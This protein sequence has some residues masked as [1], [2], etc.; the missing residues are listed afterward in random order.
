MLGCAGVAEWLLHQDEREDLQQAVGNLL[1]EGRDVDGHLAQCGRQR[2]RQTWR[3]MIQ[4]LFFF[5]VF[6]SQSRWSR[7]YNVEPEPLLSISAPAPRL[8]SR[9]Y[10]FNKYFTIISASLEDARIKNYFLPK[11][12]N[13]SDDTGITLEVQFVCC[14]TKKFSIYK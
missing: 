6:R 7:N 13:I 3:E 10:L 8:L 11:Q 1:L 5:T 4:N 14:S 2:W 12:R 9:N